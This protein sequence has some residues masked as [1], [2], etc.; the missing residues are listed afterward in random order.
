MGYN[1]QQDSTEVKIA[2][3]EREPQQYWVS[4]GDATLDEHHWVSSASPLPVRDMTRKHLLQ[5]GHFMV[6]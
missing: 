1:I 2:Q 3:I 5:A 4:M 6:M